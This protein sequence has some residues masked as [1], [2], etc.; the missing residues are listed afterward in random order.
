MENHLHIKPLEG[1]QFVPL[2]LKRSVV[3]RFRQQFVNIY[4]ILISFSTKA[5]EVHFSQI[6]LWLT[7]ITPDLEF[8]LNI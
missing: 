6:Y 3:D 5:P 8:Y 1:M 2:G 7:K 4:F